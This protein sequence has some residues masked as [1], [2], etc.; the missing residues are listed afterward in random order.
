MEALVKY[1]DL[2]PYKQARLFYLVGVYGIEPG[3]YLELYVLHTNYT[4]TLVDSITSSTSRRWETIELQNTVKA[5]EF[6]FHSDDDT[7]VDVGAMIYYIEIRA[8]IPNDAETNQDAGDNIS[9][10]T[11]TDKQEF[12][13]YLDDED[14]YTLS[15]S[16]A[17]NENTSFQVT[18][19]ENAFFNIELYNP[20]DEKIAGPSTL[21][22][23]ELPAG[24][25]KM[26][27]YSVIGFGP[28]SFKMEYIDTGGGNGGGGGGGGGCPTLFSWNGTSYVEE[29]LLDIHAASDV[30]V[31]YTLNYLDPSGRLCMLSLRELDNHTSHV[32]YVKLF[33]VDAEGNW[34]ESSLI[35]AWHTQLGSVT[36]ELLY[37]D[38]TRV[39]LSPEDET[40]LFFVLPRGIRNRQYFTFELNGYN[41]KGPGMK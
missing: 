29:A 38:D 20:A 27:I 41:P 15:I 36:T 23:L 31:D 5:I 14:W 4:S 13:G 30:T 10:P 11:S 1:I 28:Y 7:T 12:S 26:R 17:A 39:D 32:D 40:K 9:N 34:H 8:T 2:K 24:T 21:I 22:K 19:S 16:P 33:A 37:D 6:V 25:Y 18:P 35:L 3:D